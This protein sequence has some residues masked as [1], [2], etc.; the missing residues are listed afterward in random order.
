MQATRQDTIPTL[1]VAGRGRRARLRAG[2]F[3]Y[4]ML[5]ID[6]N[7]R[8]VPNVCHM[9]PGPGRHASWFGSERMLRDLEETLG[10]PR[11]AAYVRTM[12]ESVLLRV[13]RLVVQ[14]AVA[15]GELDLRSQSAL[16]VHTAL[17]LIQTQ[18][19]FNWTL[20]RLAREVGMSRTAFSQIFSRTAGVPL[21]KYLTKLRMDRAAYLPSN[22]SDKLVEVA[23]QIGY[24]SEAALHAPFICTT[25]CHEGT[26][27]KPPGANPSRSEPMHP[28]GCQ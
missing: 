26:I 25:R 7:Q 11:A 4:D 9:E 19:E 12:V 15:K 18:P 1:F 5:H 22:S 2:A 24:E 28:N 16:R 13:L 14:D 27:A 21:F 17:R 3:Q 23:H 8:L 6:P 10:E 20:D